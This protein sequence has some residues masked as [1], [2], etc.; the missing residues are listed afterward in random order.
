LIHTLVQ[1]AKTVNHWWGPADPAKGKQE[2][3]KEEEMKIIPG[4]VK[5]TPSLTEIRVNA[6]VE[7]IQFDVKKVELK[8]G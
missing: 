6:I 7:K 4:G 5:D 2:I 1:G 3:E 8:A